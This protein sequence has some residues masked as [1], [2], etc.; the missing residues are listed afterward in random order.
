MSLFILLGTTIL[1]FAIFLTSG[2]VALLASTIY[3]FSHALIA[4]PLW[5]AFIL[6]RRVAT[7]HYAYGFGRAE[8]VAGLFIVAVV[9]LSAIV[10]AWESIN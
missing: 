6:S 1:Q 5:I 7:R 10:V 9:A 3:N 4:V 8:D 2:S